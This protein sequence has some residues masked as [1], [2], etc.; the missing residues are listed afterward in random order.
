MRLFV[1]TWSAIP[2]TTL[3]TSPLF[4]SYQPITHA[5]MHRVPASRNANTLQHIEHQHTL[6][7]KLLSALPPSLAFTKLSH[8][9]A[10]DAAHY[11]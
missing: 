4:L 5:C 9:C 10:K 8:F 1:H 6:L 11:F 3:E 7:H 2:N